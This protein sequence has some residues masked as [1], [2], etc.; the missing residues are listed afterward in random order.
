MK[1]NVK[2]KGQ[3]VTQISLFYVRV[4][5]SVIYIFKSSECLLSSYGILSFVY[6]FNFVMD[7]VG[8]GLNLWLNYE[9]QN[10]SVLNKVNISQ[11]CS[12]LGVVMGCFKWF[13]P[14]YMLLQIRLCF[15][16]IHDLVHSIL[17]NVFHWAIVEISSW[18]D[19]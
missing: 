14:C 16:I 10:F 12:K 9:K 13:S 15:S 6:S 4:C 17:F 3:R 11:A 2:C 7:V 19:Y 8:F 1:G 5:L 18:F